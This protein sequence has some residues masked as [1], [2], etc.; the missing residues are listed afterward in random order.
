[1]VYP[2][3]WLFLTFGAEWALGLGSR[4]RLTED[5]TTEEGKACPTIHLALDGLEAIDVSFDWP[6]APVVAQRRVDG[7]IITS[8]PLGKPDHLR[9]AGLRALL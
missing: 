1:M 7:S 6:L 3:V 9:N 8:E 4:S 2:I 5:P